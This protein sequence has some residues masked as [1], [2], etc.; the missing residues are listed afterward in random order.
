MILGV[1]SEQRVYRAVITLT[2]AYFTLS[3][4]LL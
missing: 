3:I 4:E 1:A 2:N